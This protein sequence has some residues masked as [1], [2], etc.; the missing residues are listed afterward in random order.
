MIARG[1]DLIPGL[2]MITDEIVD[3]IEYLDFVFWDLVWFTSDSQDGPCLGRWLGFFHRVGSVLCYHILK[4]NG[5]VE[6]RTTV[7]HVTRDDLEQPGTKAQIDSF[8]T[9]LTE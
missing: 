8:N 6:S 2:E 3:I 5:K 9:A 4:S 1:S 7:Q